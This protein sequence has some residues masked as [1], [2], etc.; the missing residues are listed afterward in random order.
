MHKISLSPSQEQELRQIAQAS[1]M[2]SDDLIETYI[3]SG[4]KRSR[5][6]QLSTIAGY[7][8]ACLLT[9]LFVLI[10]L[11]FFALSA[12]ANPSPSGISVDR[13]LHWSRKFIFLFTPW[14][15]TILISL[16]LVARSGSAFWLL[17][18]L[19]GFL[20][21]IKLFGTEIELNEQSKQKIRV[22]ATEIDLAVTEYK[23]RVDREVDRLAS[24]HQMDHTFAK[25][26]D[27]AAMKRFVQSREDFRCTIHIPDPIEERRLY[28]LLDYYPIGSGHGRAFS[29][30]YGIIGKVWRTDDP[31][32]EHDLRRPPNADTL[33]ITQDTDLIIRI[34]MRDWGMTRREAEHAI[35]HR[36]YFC[37]LLTHERTKVGLVY[38]DSKHPDIFD[39]AHRNGVIEQANEDLAPMVSSLLDQL[40]S[41][42]L[43]VSLQ[44]E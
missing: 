15:I 39:E 37:F 3:L 7:L 40:S 14:P 10:G 41:V 43:Q 44:R 17:L 2:S 34:I 30:R 24:L 23:K 11:H 33:A 12:P 5:Y 4:I 21:K 27:S 9:A 1:S 35:N 32:I 6:P 22:A 25:F 28:Q 38:M 8:G 26:V 29:T 31:Q 16:W 18:G 42:S 20:R 13:L 36:S 19:F